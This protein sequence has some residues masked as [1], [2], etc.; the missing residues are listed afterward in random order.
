MSIKHKTTKTN[1]SEPEPLRGAGPQNL[2][3][4]VPEAESTQPREVVH[5]K[6]KLDETER[7]EFSK[8]EAVIETG[9]TAL[10]KSYFEVAEALFIVQKKK[11]FREAYKTFKDYLDDKHGISRQYANLLIRAHE[12]KDNLSTMVDKL[13]PTKERQ[14]RPL[15]SLKPDQQKQ[16]WG[17]AIKLAGGKPPTEKLVR[18]AVEALKGASKPPAKEANDATTVPW[19]PTLAQQFETLGYSQKFEQ[20]LKINESELDLFSAEKGHYV[21][22]M[23]RLSLEDSAL[24][25]A[26]RATK[27]SLLV[28]VSGSQNTNKDIALE[29]VQNAF[30][31][32]FNVVMHDLKAY[33][34]H[35]GKLFAAGDLGDDFKIAWT[36]V[37]GIEALL[38]QSVGKQAA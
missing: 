28:I 11:L 1:G 32:F 36:E 18:Q 22:F 23:G 15:A 4:P 31:P 12:V 2:N 9:I 34:E 27:H 26:M 8:Y 29:G 7:E 38:S 19:K 25:Q 30:G 35:D 33:L 16:A 3:K 17:D 6:P 21:K 24:V 20:P 5:H 13:Q 10:S 37:K 14:V